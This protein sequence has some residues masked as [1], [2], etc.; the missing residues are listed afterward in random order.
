MSLGKVATEAGQP[1][2]TPASPG[3]YEGVVR[4]IKDETEFNKL[5]P[6][7]VLVCPSTAPSWSVIFSTIGALVR[8]SGRGAF[9]SGNRRQGVQDT[10]G[11]FLGRSD[12]E[13]EGRAEG[14]GRRR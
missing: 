10:C 11:A 14:Q 5:R 1:R 12:A 3:S 4:V 9:S 2:G 8:G 7:D 13:A 6:G